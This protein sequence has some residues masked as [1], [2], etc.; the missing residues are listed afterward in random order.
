MRKLTKIVSALL[1]AVMLM[2]VVLCAPF[3][4]S[5]VETFTNGDYEYTILDDGTAKITKYKGKEN[6]VVIPSNTSGYSITCIGKFAFMGCKSLESVV[7]PESIKYIDYGAFTDCTNLKSVTMNDNYIN[8]ESFA[9]YECPNLNSVT[10]P[11][12]V[13]IDNWAFGYNYDEYSDKKS[14]DFTIYGYKDSKADTYAFNNDFKFIS[15]GQ[16]KKSEGLGV[17]IGKPAGDNYYCNLDEIY[18][19]SGLI[20]EFY[21]SDDYVNSDNVIGSCKALPKPA[22]IPFTLLNLPPALSL[23]LPASSIS[24]PKSSASFSASLSSLAVLSRVSLLS[25]NSFSRS[26]SVACAL[27]SFICHCCVL[28][29]FSPK[30]VDALSSAC[31]RRSILLFCSLISLLRT[32]FRAVSAST[33]L[34]FLSNCEETS[35]I[36]EPSTLKF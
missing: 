3:T 30:E 25:F 33:D 35:F 31:F 17:I 34:S 23:C 28:R 14:D 22:T 12:K 26:F 7:F 18:E 19:N 11:E 20:A 27:L 15:L 8:I 5:A 1:T 36:S 10:L 13:Y 4:V 6:E 16:A 24:S 9:F 2:S 29:S 32:L 21:S